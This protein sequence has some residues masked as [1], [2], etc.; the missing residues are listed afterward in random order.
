MSDFSVRIYTKTMAAAAMRRNCC[1]WKRVRVSIRQFII[2]VNYTSILNQTAGLMFVLLADV[3]RML[4]HS[5][6]PGQRDTDF[7]HR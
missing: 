6:C 3:N 4:R 7:A 5:I 1:C 2:V